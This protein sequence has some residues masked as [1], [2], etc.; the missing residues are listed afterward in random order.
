LAD[1][2]YAPIFTL[3]HALKPLLKINPFDGFPRLYEYSEAI[4]ALPGVQSSKV[5]NYDLLI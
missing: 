2:A 5:E 3:L 1:F 4:L